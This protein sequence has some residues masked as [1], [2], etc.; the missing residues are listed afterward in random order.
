ML[1]PFKCYTYFSDKFTLKKST[2]GWYA[3]ENPFDLDSKGKKKMAVN[4]GHQWVKC[5]KTEWS[6]SIADFIME[7]EECDYFSAKR[8]VSKYQP[9]SIDLLSI[10][11]VDA[12]VL[13]TNIKMPYG[14]TPIMYGV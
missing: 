9:G 13:A 14:Y 12:G 3:F 5:W 4:F 10:N 11:S 6:G 8:I 2:N 7:Y 1:H